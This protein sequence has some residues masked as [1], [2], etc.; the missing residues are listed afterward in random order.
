MV[1]WDLSPAEE[2]NCLSVQN[3]FRFLTAPIEMARVKAEEAKPR[4]PI[5]LPVP[6]RTHLRPAWA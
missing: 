2:K 6:P 4:Q 1:I 5:R 3:L